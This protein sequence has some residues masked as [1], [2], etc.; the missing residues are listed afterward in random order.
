VTYRTVP[1]DSFED[2]LVFLL[3]GHTRIL[4]TV[5]Q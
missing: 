5:W 3:L 4:C 2:F 1:L